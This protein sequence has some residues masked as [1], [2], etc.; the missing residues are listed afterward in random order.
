M[1]KRDNSRPTVS[2]E[3]TLELDFAEGKATF[4]APAEQND[5]EDANHTEAFLNHDHDDYSLPSL[6][7]EIERSFELEEAYY[8]TLHMRTS[9]KTKK[10]CKVKKGPS[11]KTPKVGSKKYRIGKLRKSKEHRNELKCALLEARKENIR[12]SVFTCPPNYA[13]CSDW[14][15]EPYYD[16]Q[17]MAN[18]QKEVLPAECLG[19]EDKAGYD[20]LMAILNGE[21]ITPEDYDLLLQLD[22]NNVKNTM[23]EQQISE[24]AVEVID[25][26][27]NQDGDDDVTTTT[28]STSSSQESPACQICL[29][30]FADLPTGTELRCLPCGH[31]FCKTCIDRWLCEVSHKCPNLSCY[32]QSEDFI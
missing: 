25:H 6:D 13:R 8:S 22:N 31:K 2:F 30:P 4:H 9:S 7:S 10:N 16:N 12:S 3:F 27:N 28:S 14:E 1:F 20:R 11:Q 24:I 19:V 18:Y 17:Q 21:E 23:G 29:E 5:H 15:P 26:G 32:W